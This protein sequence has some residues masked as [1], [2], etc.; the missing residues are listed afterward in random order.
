MNKNVLVKFES[1]LKNCSQFIM[2]TN[3][4]CFTMD[5][6]MDGWMDRM[7]VGQND[8]QTQY[9]LLGAII[10]WPNTSGYYLHH[11]NDS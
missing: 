5:G 9:S 6:W 3:M 11:C 10:T 8:K 7:M 1:I 4:V 2:Q